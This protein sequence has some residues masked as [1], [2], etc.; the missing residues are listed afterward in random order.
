MNENTFDV[1]FEYMCIKFRPLAQVDSGMVTS[2]FCMSEVDS[3]MTLP[4]ISR[5]IIQNLLLSD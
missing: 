2:P 1:F 3:Y 4:R 5:T